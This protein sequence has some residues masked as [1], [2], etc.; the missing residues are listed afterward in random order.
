MT[1]LQQLFDSNSEQ[2]DWLEKAT[3]CGCLPNICFL[4]VSIKTAHWFIGYFVNNTDQQTQT[5]AH[6]DMSKNI[7]QEGC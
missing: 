7:I 6:T 5:Y 3:K 4:N 1:L 2:C